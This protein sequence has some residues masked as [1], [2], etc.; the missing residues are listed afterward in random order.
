MPYAVYMDKNDTVWLTDFGTNAIM[1]FDPT[2]EKFVD[3][4]TLPT[5]GANV[6]QLLGKA[7]GR[8]MGSR[9]RIR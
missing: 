3:V 4:I 5:P 7:G 9:I 2:K 6:R 8:N 1:R